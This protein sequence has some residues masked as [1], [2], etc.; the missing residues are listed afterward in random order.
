MSDETPTPAKTDEQLEGEERERLLNIGAELVL[1]KSR[2]CLICYTGPDGEWRCRASSV[3]Y[4][5]GAAE[6]A[7]ASLLNTID[8]Q[9]AHE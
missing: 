4:A 9:Q 5:L 6:R 7:R 3:T 2:D 8:D 1:S